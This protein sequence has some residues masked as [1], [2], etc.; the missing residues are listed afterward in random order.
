M[1]EWERICERH[2]IVVDWDLCLNE[3]DMMTVCMLESECE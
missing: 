2:V 1:E 3:F